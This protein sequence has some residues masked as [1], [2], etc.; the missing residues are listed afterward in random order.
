[1]FAGAVLVV[2]AA[3]LSFAVSGSETL[4]AVAF[5]VLAAA[6]IGITLYLYQLLTRT[7]SIEQAAQ[8]AG[9]AALR[10]GEEVSAERMH[11]VVAAALRDAHALQRGV[12]RF[13]DGAAAHLADVAVDDRSAETVARL[14]ESQRAQAAR[15]EGGLAER[16]D[17]LGRHRRREAER[18]L[19]VGEWLYERLL[20]HSVLTNARHAY[21]LA[22]LTAISHAMLARLAGTA[23]DEPTRQLA[24]EIRDEAAAQA[25][26]WDDAWDA[27]L[28]AFAAQTG[29]GADAT[30][31]LL[32]EAAGMEQMRAR[33]LQVTL[34][35]AQ[36]AGVVPGAEEAG[37]QPLLAAIARERDEAGQHVALVRERARDLG[38]PT[39]RL[40]GW[41][42]F[43]AA[44]LSAGS[45]HV[46]GYKLAR[47]LRDVIASDHLEIVTYDLL[48]RAAR[49]ASDPTTADL[50]AR[51][52]AHAA[53][54]PGRWDGQFDNALEIALLAE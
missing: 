22:R 54:E 53:S 44:R 4:R 47:D 5:V 28:D 19:L 3:I 39:S 50:A 41:E 1:V 26:A 29:A 16:L 52:R 42:T 6:S 7:R 8:P 2:V 46:R 35:Q 27:V 13:A 10:L 24:E 9:D 48:E 32:D 31:A 45:E 30:H 34:A 36:E 17:S 49:R 33:L 43:A 11:D 20:A 14:L 38:R 37:L 12:Q 23:G 40:H 51:L 18:E 21:G 15:A 25:A